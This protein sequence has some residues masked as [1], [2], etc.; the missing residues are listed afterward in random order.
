MMMMSEYSRDQKR[1]KDVG[2]GQQRSRSPHTARDV[3]TAGRREADWSRD[4]NN[5][6]SSEITTVPRD[7]HGERESRRPQRGRRDVA[8]PTRHDT[9]ASI[10]VR[11][12]HSSHSD[13]SAGLLVLLEYDRFGC[14]AD[15]SRYRYRCLRPVSNLSYAM[16]ALENAEKC[17]T[18]KDGICS[19]LI[20]ILAFHFSALLV[21]VRCLFHFFTCNADPAC[22]EY[23]MLDTGLC[24]AALP[25]STVGGRGRVC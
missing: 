24:T 15:V 16:H 6:A 3:P 21:C 10:N 23:D 13:S 19:S 1:G 12:R 4:V 11:Q 5:P 17:N 2:R 22:A 25:D 18:C 8:L 7:V 20:L 9:A 14:N